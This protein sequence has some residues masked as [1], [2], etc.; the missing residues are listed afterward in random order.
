VPQQPTP[1]PPETDGNEREIS[2]KAANDDS[3]KV[4]AAWLAARGGRRNPK[5]EA[6]VRASATSLLAVGRSIP[7]VIAIAED[8]AVNYPTGKD[9]T[10]H[11]DHFTAQQR[12][13]PTR[14]RPWCGCGG[15]PVAEFNGRF[16]T[17]NGLASGQP[18]LI[19]HPDALQE[20]A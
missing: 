17:H 15:N 8:M 20:S 14:L 1:E 10:I 4:V 16:R 13:S 5:A 11:D 19:C 6:A 12:A 2:A 3:A 18:C 7:D 9:L